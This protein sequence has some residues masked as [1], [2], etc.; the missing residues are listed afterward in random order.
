MRTQIT[1]KELALQMARGMDPWKQVF[2]AAKVPMIGN[3]NT[4]DGMGPVKS[5][6]DRST[7]VSRRC[8]V[9][10]KMPSGWPVNRFAWARM[11]FRVVIEAIPE[12]RVPEK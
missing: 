12:G 5:L 3:L 8:P 11:V 6:K 10:L 1:F 7:A 9:R 2:S 4:S